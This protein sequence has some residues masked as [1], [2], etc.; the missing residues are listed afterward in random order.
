MFRLVGEN[1]YRLETTGGYYALLK[2]GSKQIRRSLKTGDRKLAERRLAEFRKDVGNLR[3]TPDSSLPYREIA[4]RWLAATRHALKAAS[5][6][7]R[8]GCIIATAP[9][10]EGLA[11]RNVGREH[12]ERWVTERGTSI[13]AQSF[14][15][16]LGTMKGVFAYA[17]DAGLILANPAAHIARRRIPKAVINVPSKSEFQLLIATIRESDGRLDSQLKAAPGADLVELLAY[18]GM[19][20]GEA[21]ALLWRYVDFHRGVVM[22]TGGEAGTKNHEHRVVPMTGALRGLLQR[23]QRERAPK[24]DDLVSPIRDAKTTLGKACKRL[25]LRHFHHH[26]FRHFFATTCIEAGVDIPTISKWLGHKDGGALAMRVY[27]HLREEHSF[28]QI[29]RVS[30]AGETP[31]NPG[32]IAFPAAGLAEHPSAQLDVT[33]QA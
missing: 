31:S 2:T 24:P 16:E 19:R 9:F 10:F 21:T 25:G 23:I 17:V 6:R 5:I 14:A 18:S 4:N 29:R 1:L 26:D 33:R 28:A 11:I 27:G 8:E 15:H 7:R 22:V 13:S 3:I 30:F 20:L 32:E 12:V